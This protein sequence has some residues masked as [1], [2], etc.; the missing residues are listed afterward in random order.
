MKLKDILKSVSAIT[1]S[2]L[3][4]ASCLDDLNRDPEYDITGDKVYETYSGYMGGITKVYAAYALTGN[5]GPGNK[6]DISGLDE[7]LYADFLRMFFNHQELPTDETHCIW[8]QDE[9]IPGLNNMNFSSENPFTKGLYNRS[10]TQIMYA[11]EFIRNSSDGEINGKGFS[12]DQIKEI[13]YFRAESRFIRAFQYWVL[14]DLFGN[15]PFIT[16]EHELNILPEQ[17]NRNDLFNYIESELKDI[18]ENNLLKEPQT[19]EYGRADKAAAWALLARL[20]LNAETYTGNAKY[21]EAA[22][23]AEKVINSGYSLKPDY[24][25]LFLANNNINNPEVILSIN[26]DGER[27]RNNGGATF[28]VNCG[29]NSG[30]QATYAD[31]L[32]NYGIRENANWS[33]YRARKEFSERWDENDKRRLFVGEEIS[34]TDA[35]EF[36]QGLATYKWRNITID[37]SGNWE[38]GAHIAFA[39]NDFPL[40]RLAEMYLIYAEAVKR[41]GEGSSSKALEYI[42]K[43][44]ERA[45]GNTNHNYTVFNNVTLEDILNERGFELY[46]EAH[47]RTDLIRFGMFSGSKYI[48]EWKGGIRNGRA[49][50]SHYNLYPLPSSDLMANPN[51]KQNPNY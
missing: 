21:T 50:S 42:N 33:G 51:L 43:L 30:Y 31:I 45:F 40:F 39:D 27:T 48:W 24:Q 18:T 12:E 17:I 15:P 37:A 9:G 25:Q 20:Y 19:N 5:E 26:Y 28:L 29:S 3:L 8:R 49:V 11:N 4:Y 23:Y 46:W 36:K 38:Y 6:P 35:I 34:I 13:K 10:I 47:R 2:I 41:G 32:L 7:G 16:D 1:F 44:R 14:M 22:Q